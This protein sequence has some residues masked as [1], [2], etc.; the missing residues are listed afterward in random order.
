LGAEKA[1]RRAQ[2][3]L[4][5]VE[6]LGRSF[7]DFALDT[8]EDSSVRSANQLH[9]AR[10]NE[11][12]FGNHVIH[13]VS[14]GPPPQTTR[15][16]DTRSVVAFDFVFPAAFREAR[17]PR[18]NLIS[19]PFVFGVVIRPP[20]PQAHGIVLV[21]DGFVVGF[22]ELAAPLGLVTASFFGNAAAG[23]VCAGKLGCSGRIIVQVIDAI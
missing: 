20:Q 7:S 12:F 21:L 13:R 2:E 4:R 8:P 18:R 17:W 6:V 1:E 10:C 23:S 11:S 9:G 16:S 5:L 15:S 22:D 3:K 14:S 19:L